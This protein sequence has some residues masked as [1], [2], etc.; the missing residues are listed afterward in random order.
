MAAALSPS[1]RRM[2]VA[3]VGQQ[4]ETVSALITFLEPGRLEPLGSAEITGELPLAAFSPD[5]NHICILTESGVYF[6]SGEGELLG[7]YPFGGLRLLSYHFAEEALFINAGRNEGGQHSSLICLS[8][9]GAVLGSYQFTEGP[10]SIGAAGR[11]CAVLEAGVLLRF[12]PEGAELKSENLGRSAARGL[13]VDSKG[14]ILLL[15]SGYARWYNVNVEPW[16]GEDDVSRMDITEFE[17]VR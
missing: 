1:G 6:Y 5:N 9:T 17:E 10:D 4:G 8:Y 11:W 2:A 15:Y 12:S 3:A 7:H 14:D 16:D 13:L